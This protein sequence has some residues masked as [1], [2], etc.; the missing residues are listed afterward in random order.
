MREGTLDFTAS[1]WWALFCRILLTPQPVHA[2][3]TGQP[4][5]S[6]KNAQSVWAHLPRRVFGRASAAP[7]LPCQI[8]E[9]GTASFWL[10]T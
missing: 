8:V 2:V 4:A 9:P 3:A 5:G 7:P 1:G 6:R 10:S